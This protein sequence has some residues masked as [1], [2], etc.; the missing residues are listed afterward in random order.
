TRAVR[1]HRRWRADNLQRGG[2]D[3]AVP[4][5]AVKR[6]GAASRWSA[7]PDREMGPRGSE[8]LESSR[9]NAGKPGLWDPSSLLRDGAKR[10]LR[11]PRSRLQ[12]DRRAR[13][14]RI[15]LLSEWQL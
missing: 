8:Q 4:R 9:R 2:R 14:S 5:E 12:P 15:A 10:P 1:L 7:A 6:R 11:L 3:R 13:R